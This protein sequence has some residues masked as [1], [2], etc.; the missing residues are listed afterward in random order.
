MKNFTYFHLV[1]LPALLFCIV[2]FGSCS[3]LQPPSLR[4]Y[5]FKERG[6]VC[7]AATIGGN[8]ELQ[9]AYS[10]MKHVYIQSGFRHDKTNAYG[11]YSDINHYNS[12]EVGVGYYKAIKSN[13]YFQAGAE[14]FDGHGKIDKLIGGSNIEFEYSTVYFKGIAVNGIFSYYSEFLKKGIMIGARIGKTQNAEMLTDSPL[15]LHHH[16][17]GILEHRNYNYYEGCMSIY[18][19][20]KNLSILAFNIDISTHDPKNY[21]KQFTGTLRFS[22]SYQI[23]FNIR[24]KHKVN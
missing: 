9:A 11:L 13:S 1:K 16:D 14:I 19:R 21:F 15:S 20:Y 24:Q 18:Q 22:L 5:N 3:T 7:I 17:I 2:F 10:P 12:Q 23:P 4:S 8:Y 6:D